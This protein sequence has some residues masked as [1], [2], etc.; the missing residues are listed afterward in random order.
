MQTRAFFY[1]F[2]DYIYDFR[3]NLCTITA[4]LRQLLLCRISCVTERKNLYRFYAV[5]P[6]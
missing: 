5:G 1:C 4:T 3:V 6:V 2:E